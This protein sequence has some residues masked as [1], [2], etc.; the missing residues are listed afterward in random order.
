MRRLP[1]VEAAA[2]HAAAEERELAD[3]V[4]AADGRVHRSLRRRNRPRGRLRLASL[5]R[6]SRRAAG[7]PRKSPPQK[8]A[9]QRRARVEPHPVAVEASAPAHREV[10]RRNPHLPG[11]PPAPRRKQHVAADEKQALHAA[12]EHERAL[13]ADAR[14]NPVAADAD[15]GTRYRALLVSTFDGRMSRHV[16]R[17]ISPI[18]IAGS[19]VQSEMLRTSHD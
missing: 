11:S 13:H 1:Q 15:I 14:R 9:P 17:D 18:R 10:E 16:N 3:R 8:R 19:I 4:A 5:Q 7:R 6:K 12:V 2:R